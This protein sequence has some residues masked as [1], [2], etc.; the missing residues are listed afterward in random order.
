MV[1]GSGGVITL[2]LGFVCSFSGALVHLGRLFPAHAQRSTLFFGVCRMLQPSLA[3]GPGWG[4]RLVSVPPL[5]PA[6]RHSI[7]KL[8][9]SLHQ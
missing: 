4:G 9:T 5:G 8:K 1:R 6:R 7:Q 3:G 2:Y